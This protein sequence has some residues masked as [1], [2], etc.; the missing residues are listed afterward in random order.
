MSPSRS[1]ISLVA[2]RIK[3]AFF[4]QFTFLFLGLAFCVFGW[5]LQYKLSLYDPPHA[6]SHEIP[7]AK[8][9]SNDEKSLTVESRLVK[10]SSAAEK[11]VQTSFYGLFFALL[12][13][14]TAPRGLVRNGKYSHSD[15]P[16]RPS[17]FASLSAFFFRPPPVL[18]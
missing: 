9:L 3:R 10:R 13:A 6:V 4:S 18:A 16:V 17:N 15:Q 14:L 1:E 8:L 12:L 2:S 5:G 7:Q 11:V